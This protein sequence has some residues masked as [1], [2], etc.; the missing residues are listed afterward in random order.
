MSVWTVTFLRR[1]CWLTHHA[2]F[3]KQHRTIVTSIMRAVVL[4]T[5]LTSTDPSWDV[6]YASMLVVVESNL[7]IICGTLPTLRKF[8]RH[9]APKLIGEGSSSYAQH[10]QASKSFGGGGGHY[11]QSSHSAPGAAAIVT[12]GSL[13]STHQKNGGLGHH[14]N[15]HRGYA[16]FDEYAFALETIGGTHMYHPA[17]AHSRNKEQE[18]QQQLFLGSGVVGVFR[19]GSKKGR[20][21]TTVVAGGGGV[22]VEADGHH[23]SSGGGGVVGMG[24]GVSGRNSMGSRESQMPIMGGGGGG[25]AEAGAGHS[26]ATGITATTR[27]EVSYDRAG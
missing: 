18:P 23:A 11:K 24:G 21:D 12:F 25:G 13:P 2:R 9:V 15:S 14:H 16:K 26:G 10:G 8:V 7:I 3:F 1:D 17:A 20:V 27:I 6:A 4:P 22:D 19:S 5:L